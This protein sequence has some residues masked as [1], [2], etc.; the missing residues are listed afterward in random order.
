MW[1]IIIGVAFIA[2]GLSGQIALRGT[3]SGGA[4]A[5]LGGGLVIWGIVQMVRKKSE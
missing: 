5:A 3:E 4:I 2:G 1:N